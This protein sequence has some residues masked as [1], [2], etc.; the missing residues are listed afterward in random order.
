MPPGARAIDSG[1]VIFNVLLNSFIHSA[2]PLQLSMLLLR[3]GCSRSSWRC[4][5]ACRAL[6]LREQHRGHLLPLRLRLLLLREQP[7]GLLLPLRLL[8]LLREQSHGLLLPLL[9]RLLLRLLLLCYIAAAAAA[10]AAATPPR[11]TPLA[12]SCPL[13][14]SLHAA[15]HCAADTAARRRPTE[16]TGSSGKFYSYFGEPAEKRCRLG[17]RRHDRQMQGRP[18]RRRLLVAPCQR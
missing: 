9:L 14:R 8:L 7:R 17:R 4:C 13:A 5:C 10:L 18:H 16:N 2:V 12:N 3:E 6:L 1:L 15:C 11:A